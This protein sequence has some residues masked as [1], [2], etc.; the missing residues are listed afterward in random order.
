MNLLLEVFECIQD[1]IVVVVSL[2]EAVALTS[3]GN[4][5]DNPDKSN[6]AIVDVVLFED[7]GGLVAVDF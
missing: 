3:K 2:A 5:D 6:Y 7:R 1:F 4:Q